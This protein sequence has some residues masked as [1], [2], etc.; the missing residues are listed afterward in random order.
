[1]M[2]TLEG[3]GKYISKHSL[4]VEHTSS[5]NSIWS[6]SSI[7]PGNPPP[8]SSKFMIIPVCSAISKTFRAAKIASRYAWASK[9]PDPTWKETPT[10]LR[11]KLIAISNMLGTSE[12]F[13]PNL[14]PRGHRAWADETKTLRTSK[15][16]GWHFFIFSNS[17]SESKVINLTW[18]SRAN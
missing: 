18:F 9:H 16:E 3:S 15:A 5:K 1:M 14:R 8:M 7:F 2:R 10:M 11:F 4:M 17:C 12:I 6:G 13:A